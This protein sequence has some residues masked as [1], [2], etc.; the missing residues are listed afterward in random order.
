MNNNYLFKIKRCREEAEMLARN[1]IYLQLQ[2]LVIY[3]NKC[4]KIIVKFKIDIELISTTN[5]GITHAYAIRDV[6]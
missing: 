6:L 2:S 4:R 5:R 3:A 1:D